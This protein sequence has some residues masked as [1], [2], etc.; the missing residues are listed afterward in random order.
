LNATTHH[1]GYFGALAVYAKCVVA[2]T[3]VLLFIG[4]L[5]TSYQAG[6]AVPDWPLSFGS[7]NPEGWWGNLPVRLEHGHRQ[8]ALVIGMLVTILCAWTWRNGWPLLI[9]A[10]AAGIL[11][12]A[13]KAAGVA[14]IIVMHVGIWSF[15]G[16][17]AITLL[18]MSKNRAP[19][20]SRTVRVLAFAAFLGVALQATL[21]GLRVTVETAGNL[22]LALRLRILHACVAQAE[23][24]LLV[25]AATLLSR[26][27]IVGDWKSAGASLVAVR[28]FAWTVFAAVYAQ[29][30]VGAMMRHKG[31]G[32]AISSF[33]E[34]DDAGHWMPRVHN[35]FVDLNFTHTRFGAA[36]VTL[37]IFAL[38]LLVLRRARGDVRLI[39]PAVGLLGL[40]LIQFA[41]GVYVIW[42]VKPIT[43]TTIHVVNGAAVLAMSLLLALRTGRYLPE[44][45]PAQIQDHAEAAA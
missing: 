39:S 20:T 29:L 9:A 32:L 33:P 40:V 26:A 34:V 2:A 38:V 45:K 42:H 27:W 12:P 37:M 5:V 44:S 10:V 28:R 4:G 1:P 31:A 22:S 15:A 6:M 23:L 41:L 35:T 21:G 8:F 13:A 3:F 30:I 16:A 43:L 25:A 7:V 18:V 24:S 19:L 14:P 17:F 36:L 11:S